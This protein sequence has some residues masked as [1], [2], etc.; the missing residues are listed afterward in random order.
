MSKRVRRRDQSLQLV[1]LRLRALDELS[2]LRVDSLGVDSR[3]PMSLGSG[4][5]PAT[6]Y[7]FAFKLQHPIF[8]KRAGRRSIGMILSSC[9]N[10]IPNLR[11]VSV[12][13]QCRCIC[14]IG[15]LSAIGG[16]R[17]VCDS[18][19]CIGMGGTQEEDF[20]PIIGS[21]AAV[22]PTLDLDNYCTPT[23]GSTSFPFL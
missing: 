6:V 22:L 23:V 3:L 17:Y 1:G 16:G 10:R 18:F 9:F 15:L 8:L 14:D 21:L 12:G 5:D 13:Q 7:Q 2:V 19:H 11:G 20:S 4:L